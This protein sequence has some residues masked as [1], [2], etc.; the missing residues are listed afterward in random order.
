MQEGG[1]IRIPITSHF[2]C[3]ASGYHIISSQCPIYT[4][5]GN[6]MNTGKTYPIVMGDRGFTTFPEII[7]KGPHFLPI[8][9]EDSYGL[10]NSKKIIKFFRLISIESSPTVLISTQVLKM[11]KK[12]VLLHAY[13]VVHIFPACRELSLLFFFNFPLLILQFGRWEPRRPLVALQQ[14]DPMAVLGLE[15]GS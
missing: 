14:V 10:K 4:N 5:T 1:F 15:L 8:F 11:K 12:K 3:Q 7:R 6:S 9:I 13:Y 2:R